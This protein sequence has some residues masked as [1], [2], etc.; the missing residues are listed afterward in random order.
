MDEKFFNRFSC[1]AFFGISSVFGHLLLLSVL[2]TAA[3]SPA[4]AD[5]RSNRQKLFSGDAVQRA[6]EQ[7]AY[8]RGSSSNDVSNVL[9]GFGRNFNSFEDVLLTKNFTQAYRGNLRSYELNVDLTRG[10][11]SDEILDS[12][13]RGISEHLLVYQGIVS[14]TEMIENSPFER[15]MKSVARSV[16]RLRNYTTVHVAENT[17]GKLKLRRGTSP[18]EKPLMQLKLDANV[19]RG[20]GPK[21][22][23]KD[24]MQ[25][26]VDAV[27]QRAL[28][29]FFINY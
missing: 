1:A 3:V 7:Q 24:F 9:S 5:D 18:S 26:R 28:L 15:M 6:D 27:K 22:E 23:I 19:N 4:R 11:G 14:F 25:I 20:V 8:H 17:H 16:R 21:L 2:I 12:E 10:T 29:E 13:E